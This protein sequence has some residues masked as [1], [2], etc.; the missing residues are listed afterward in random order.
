MATCS[1]ISGGAVQ[2]QEQRCYY[3][4][5]RSNVNTFVAAVITRIAVV[6]A[7]NEDKAVAARIVV[8]AEIEIAYAGLVAGE[9]AARSSKAVIV[10]VLFA[11]LV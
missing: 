2:R 7:I 10:I 11:I 4:A 9:A 8:V 1:N 3:H 6:A 5:A